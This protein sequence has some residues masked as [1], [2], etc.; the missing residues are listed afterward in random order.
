MLVKYDQSFNPSVDGSTPQFMSRLFCDRNGRQF[1][2]T[3]LV[4]VINGEFKGRLICAEPISSSVA[5]LT[6]NVSDGSNGVF[7][8]PITCDEAKPATKYVS[9]FAPVAS[10]YFSLEFLINSQPTRAPSRI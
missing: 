10:P 8:L 5:K 1:R 3:F 6:G 9:A 2:L 7:Y 4:T